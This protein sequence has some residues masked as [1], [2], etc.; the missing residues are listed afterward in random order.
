MLATTRV[1]RVDSLRVRLTPPPPPSPYTYYLR[2]STTSTTSTQRPA[3]GK[4]TRTRTTSPSSFTST[5]RP[6]CTRPAGRLRSEPQRFRRE[7]GLQRPPATSGILVS[8]HAPLPST[9][10]RA[11]RQRR[12]SSHHGATGELQSLLTACGISLLVDGRAGGTAALCGEYPYIYD[13]PRDEIAHD[14]PAAQSMDQS[15]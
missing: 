8:K 11:Q 15:C 1:S 3:S 10:P 14:W 5:P 13:D 9:F 6:S 12:L 7:I 4:T 2:P